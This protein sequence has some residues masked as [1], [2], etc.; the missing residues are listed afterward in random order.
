[1]EKLSLSQAIKTL[2]YPGSGIISGKSADGSC[3]ISA[4]FICGVGMRMT[5]RVFVED[6]DSISIEAF[7]IE[8][9]PKNL[10]YRPIMVNENRLLIGNSSHVEY[11]YQKY[12]SRPRAACAFSDVKCM[13]DEPFFTPRISCLVD[14]SG[15]EPNYTFNIAKKSGSAALNQTF[16][17]SNIENGTGYMLTAFEGSSYPPMAYEGEPCA[18]KLEGSIFDVV[19]DVWENL[20]SETRVSLWVRSIDLHS[21]KAISRIINRNR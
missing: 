1:M 11:L 7:G 18:I 10:L 16:N 13:D 21:H 14:I 19:A 2:E 9:I 6:G 3:A 17:I 8:E 15:H 20:R 12:V 4:F 5:N